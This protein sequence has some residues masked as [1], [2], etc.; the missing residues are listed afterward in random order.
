MKRKNLRIIADFFY[1][2]RCPVCA[3][4]IGANDT[5]CP[6]CENILRKYTENFNIAGCTAF[7]AAY[8]Y[9]PEMSEAV[10]LMKRGI[11][12]NAPFAFCAELAERIISAGM[13]GADMLVPVPMFFRDRTKRGADQ[14][15]LIAK[16]LSRRLGIPVRRAVRK[17]HP[18]RTQK[19]LSAEERRINLEGAFSVRDAE[20]VRDKTVIVVD[21]VCTTGSTLA[22]MTKI[23][24]AAGAEKVYCACCCKT[25]D[26]NHGGNKND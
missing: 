26:K 15:Y 2:T 8:E 18:T 17:T 19:N 3:E 10:F 14:T 12:G 22:E 4:F 25:P 21:D 23:L 16:E 24:L 6:D 11:V 13:D 5:F 1:P 7:T 9:R 20:T